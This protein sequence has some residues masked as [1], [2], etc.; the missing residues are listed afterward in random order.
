MGL[1]DLSSDDVDGNDVLLDAVYHVIVA[2]LEHE[3]EVMLVLDH[4]QLVLS[5]HYHIS[6]PEQL[7]L[8]LVLLVALLLESLLELF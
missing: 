7:V 6:L 1:V 8:H 5:C 3:F 2:A 4:R